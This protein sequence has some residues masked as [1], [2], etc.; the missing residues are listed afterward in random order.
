MVLSFE[1]KVSKCPKFSGH[2]AGEDKRYVRT[3]DIHPATVKKIL[4]GEKVRL[5]PHATEDGWEFNIEVQHVNSIRKK[6]LR[7]FFR[8]GFFGFEYMIDNIIDHQSC[9][10]P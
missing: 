6:E 4:N 5:F 7:Q 10:K 9:E 2:W 8:N 3:K 1:L